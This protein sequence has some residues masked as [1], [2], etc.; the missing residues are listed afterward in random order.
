MSA[1]ILLLQDA[2]YLPSFGGGNKA[3]R[4]LLA[5]LARRG[6]ECRV[7]SRSPGERRLLAHEFGAQG[8]AARGVSIGDDGSYHH[9]GI[10]ILPLDFAAPA[11][12]ARIE[13][14][15][16]DF[17]PDW[18][19]A[20][21]DRPALFLD[22]ALRHA[23]E[24]V[25][26]LVHTHFHLPFGPE[27][28]RLDQVQHERLRQVRSVVAVS[29]YS[30]TY[31]RDHGGIDSTLLRFPVFGHAPLASIEPPGD[32]FVAMINPCLAK[33]LPIFLAL[34]ERFPDIP[35]AAVPTWGG[36]PA[37][38]DTLAQL[39]NVML[40]DPVDDIGTLLTRVRVLLAPS[41][42]P[43]TLGY[44]AID[45]ML[46]GIPVLAGNL[47]GQPEAKL[48]VD[49][50]LPVTPLDR[51]EPQPIEAWHVALET[52]LT[53]ARAYR[54]LSEQSRD[55]AHR[56]LPETDAGH[57]IRHLDSL[58]GRPREVQPPDHYPAAPG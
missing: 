56:F 30:R 32:G 20:S 19:L 23:S 24:R 46:R 9:Q 18:I 7:V 28:D 35:F 50:V 10:H 48:G 44:V 31:L 52:L 37:V 34:A 12:A 5:E 38:L 21:D 58:S 40:L 33:G 17:D 36:D 55:A 14:L 6:F 39:P 2:V 16:R 57:F 25:I 13:A 51:S 22:I 43:E 29:E 11:A 42:V 15:I 47:G 53:D 41:L 45:A 3:N 4:L 49:H 54:R 8:L 26:A 1:R 27:A